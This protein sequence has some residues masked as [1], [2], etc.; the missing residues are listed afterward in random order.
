[1]TARSFR[2]PRPRAVW[3]ALATAVVICA[4][5]VIGVLL[6]VLGL[7][8]TADATTIGALRVPVGAITASI[9]VSYLVGLGFLVLTFLSRWGALAWITAVAAVIATLIGSVWPLI[10]TA[11]ASVDQAQQVVPFIERLIERVTG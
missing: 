10:A 1:M 2:R 7:I 11:F 5:I 6:P 9:V 8:G 3:A 4:L